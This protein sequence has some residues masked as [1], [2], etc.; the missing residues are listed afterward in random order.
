MIH[1]K[2][3]ANYMDT[4]VGFGSYDADFWLVGMEQGGGRDL[5]DP[6][7]PQLDVHSTILGESGRE[8]APKPTSDPR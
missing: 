3:L 2:L 8:N 6:H 1:E 5:E 7:W 4:F